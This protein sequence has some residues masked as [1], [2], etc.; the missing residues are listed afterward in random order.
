M[1][2]EV[3]DP[4]HVLLSLVSL[5]QQPVAK[6]TPLAPG[7]SALLL[8]KVGGYSSFNRGSHPPPLCFYRSATRA[9]LSWP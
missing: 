2:F 3:R 8:Y 9:N 5:N 4:L 7:A 1:T 6:D